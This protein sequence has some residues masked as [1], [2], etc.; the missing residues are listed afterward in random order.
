MLQFPGISR[1]GNSRESTL[2]TPL[3]IAFPYSEAKAS[4]LL[5]H[6]QRLSV[7]VALINV[8]PGS[9]LGYGAVDGHKQDFVDSLNK[10]VEYCKAVNC[11]RSGKATK[12]ISLDT[13]RVKSFRIFVKA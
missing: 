4:V 10:S 1:S 3:Q 8:W 6:S 11:K 7:D 2:L 9:H 13:R 12:K 5:A